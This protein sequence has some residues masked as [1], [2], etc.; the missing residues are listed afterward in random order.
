MVYKCIYIDRVDNNWLAVPLIVDFR[1]FRFNTATF[2]YCR[3][4]GYDIHYPPVI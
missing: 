2:D 3:L 1:M 4:K